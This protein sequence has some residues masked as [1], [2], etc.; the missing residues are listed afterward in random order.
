[1]TVY[2]FEG[3]LPG[4]HGS[5]RI[6]ETS[7]NDLRVGDSGALLTLALNDPIFTLAD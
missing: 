3:T 2:G 5:K 7:I 6:G 4:R 1:M